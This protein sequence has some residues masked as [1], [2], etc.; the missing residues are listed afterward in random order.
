[1]TDNYG[2]E[3]EVGA[4]VAYNWSGQIAVGEVVRIT[5]RGTIWISLHL[6]TWGVFCRQK[7]SISKVHNPLSCLVLR[8]ADGSRT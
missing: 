2:N 6:P 1:M 3:V 5:P 7:S 4:I 8:R